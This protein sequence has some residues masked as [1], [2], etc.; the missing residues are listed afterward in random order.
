MKVA[1]RYMMTDNEM[2][3]SRKTARQK[4]SGIHITMEEL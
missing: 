4:V 2:V 1:W 3:V